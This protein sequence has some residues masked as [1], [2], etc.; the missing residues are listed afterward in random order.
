MVLG[1]FV[2]AD[3]GSGLVHMAPA[4]GADDYQAGIEHGLALVRPV[5]ADGTLFGTSWPEIE[6]RL[7]TARETNDLII[8]RLKQ[9]GR[10]H[11]TAPHTHTYPHCWRCGSAL[12][13]Y[14]RDSWFVRTSAVKDRMLELNAQVD[15]HPPEVGAGRF[16]EWLENNVD[17][18]L[19][20]DRYWG[21]PLPVWVCDQDPAHVEVIGSYAQLAERLGP[22]AARRLRSP[23]AA[24]RR[25]Y[26][27][28]L[29]RRHACGGRP[30]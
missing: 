8:Q 2:T 23:Q 30:R 10:W 18:A 12:I 5:A 1:D 19:S 26:V 13:Y 24:H 17:W 11:L 9:D 27:A 6:G 15:W 16:G 25:L 7:V 14:A 20:R 28:L 22:A 21:T 4:F 29:L 3:D